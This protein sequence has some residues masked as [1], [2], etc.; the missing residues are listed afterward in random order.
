MRA[1]YNFLSDIIYIM[2]IVCFIMK[3]LRNLEVI[4]LG[5]IISEQNLSVNMKDF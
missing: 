5:F 3:N 1:L 2:L 4:Y